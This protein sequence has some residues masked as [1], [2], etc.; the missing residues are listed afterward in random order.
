MGLLANLIR[1]RRRGR[2]AP[3]PRA[4]FKDALWVTVD[5]AWEIGPPGNM[6]RFLSALAVM[7]GENWTLVLW[8]IYDSD[9]DAYAIEHAAPI[10]VP[11]GYE[12]QGR[13]GTVRAIPITAETMR[14]LAAVAANT[15]TALISTHTF[16]LA[17]D[18]LVLQWFDSPHDD[19]LI[20]KSVPR[21]DMDAFREAIGA[22]IIDESVDGEWR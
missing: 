8:G 13:S 17:G 7:A 6:E 2:K 10:F 1:W 11:K 12:R 19:F 16:V 18:D 21:E 3:G 20:A 15:S 22:R 14:G 5:N 4:R 9:I